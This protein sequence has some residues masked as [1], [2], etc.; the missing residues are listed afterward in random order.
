LKSRSF[1][2]TVE[3]WLEGQ[4]QATDAGRA[5]ELVFHNGGADMNLLDHSA[6]LAVV[7]KRCGLDQVRALGGSSEPEI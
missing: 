1:P 5:A 3:I 7:H 6:T 4:A 2:Q